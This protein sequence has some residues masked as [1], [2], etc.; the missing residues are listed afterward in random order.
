MGNPSFKFLPPPVE[1]SLRKIRIFLVKFLNN[2]AKTMP[3]PECLKTLNR[4]CERS[5]AIHL[6]PPKSLNL[7]A[8]HPSHAPRHRLDAAAAGAY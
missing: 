1:G 8:S 3:P 5:E 4:H 6:L 7:P 2:K